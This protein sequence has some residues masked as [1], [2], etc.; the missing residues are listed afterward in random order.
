MSRAMANLKRELQLLE[1]QEKHDR[2]KRDWNMMRKRVKGEKRN[3]KTWKRTCAE[4]CM[5]RVR[6]LPVRIRGA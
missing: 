1:L 5:Q 4:M 3:I 2:M 6:N